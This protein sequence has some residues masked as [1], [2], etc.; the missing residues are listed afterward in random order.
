MAIKRMNTVLIAVEDLE[1]A[2]AF[3]IELGMVLSGVMAIGG[4][5]VDRVI[6]IEN[7]RAEIAAL[8]M[9][10]GHSRI[11]LNTGAVT[12]YLSNA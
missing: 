8:Q 10:D 7:T 6:G 11:T 3:F 4:D 9:P 5:W 12:A 2:K 1:A